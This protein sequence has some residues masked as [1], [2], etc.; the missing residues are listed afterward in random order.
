M[1][2]IDRE[3]VLAAYA[4]GLG[5]DRIG[6]LLKCCPSSAARIVRL[7]GLTRPAH[8]RWKI[9]R[10]EIVADYKAGMTYRAIAGKHGCS[11]FGVLYH[12]RRAGVVGDRPPRPL[13]E[14]KFCKYCGRSLRPKRKE[15]SSGGV[16]NTCARRKYRNG[17]CSHCG[18]PLRHRPPCCD[19]A[20]NIKENCGWDG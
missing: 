17:I 13:R 20:A 6:R 14:S 7:A 2:R 5:C 4:E 19:R 1:K 9:N 3:A 12:L 18:E 16:C 8:L 15:H 10:A 11:K